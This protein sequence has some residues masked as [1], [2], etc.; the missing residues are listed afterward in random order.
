MYILL[1]LKKTQT[2]TIVLEVKIVV[3]LRGEGR[4]QC[5]EGSMEVGAVGSA[6]SVLAICHSLGAH[7]QGVVK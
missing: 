1:Q 2:S 3:N 5:L 6:S 7:Y 4:G